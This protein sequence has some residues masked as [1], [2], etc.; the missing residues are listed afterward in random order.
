MGKNLPVGMHEVEDAETILGVRCD[1]SEDQM[2]GRLTE[3]YRKW[4]ARVTNFDPEVQ[5]QADQML[6]FIAEA[7]DEYVS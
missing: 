3:E 1:M 2:R 4:N 6:R 7:R 5:S